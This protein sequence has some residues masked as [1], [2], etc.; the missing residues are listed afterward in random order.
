[1]RLSIIVPVY[2]VE[3]YLSK[4]IESI[5]AQTFTDFELILVDDG[6]PDRCGEI[7]DKYAQ[8]DNRVVVIHKAN[9]GVSSSRNAGIEKATGEY[10]GFVDSDDYISPTMYEQMLASAER[11]SA[12]IVICGVYR[13]TEDGQIKNNEIFAKEIV[14]AKDEVMHDILTDKL[15]NYTW[16]KIYKKKL[17]KGLSYPIGYNYEDFAI[18][19][20]L[21]ER[22]KVFV[23][24]PTIGYF[25][26]KHKFSIT[27]CIS[28][29]NKYHQFYFL[30][31]REY[32]ASLHYPK[33]YEDCH[34]LTI[35]A[36]LSAYCYNAVGDNK[37]VA[38]DIRSYLNKIKNTPE[39][40]RK[41]KLRK[42]LWLRMILASQAITKYY[43]ALSKWYRN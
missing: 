8:Q 23:G 34:K 42:Q 20:L 43:S 18:N 24:I 33:S 36:A 21:F 1:M 2:K 5:L 38:E 4:C 17:F 37:L 40:M 25:Y 41:L 16:N 29:L 6:S 12:D 7:C 27:G 13:V 32:F 3:K 28:A 11:H 30:R 31:E 14:F 39:E 35:K 22:G 19:Y 15:K 26:L 9:G 10:I